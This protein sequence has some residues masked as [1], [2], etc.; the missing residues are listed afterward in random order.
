MAKVHYPGIYNNP[1]IEL[2]TCSKYLV[3]QKDGSTL[4]TGD[5]LEVRVPIRYRHYGM[6]E[7]TSNV[8]TLGLMDLIIDDKYQT[9]LNIMARVVL[10]PSESEETTID[11]TPYL[12]MYFYKGDTFMLTDNVLMDSD[13]NYAVYVEYITR[14]HRLYT[15]SYDD[16]PALFDRSKEL[17]GKAIDPLTLE[18]MVSHI[19][20]DPKN[21]SNQYRYTDFSK[22]PVIIH[23]RSINLSPTSTSTRMLGSYED[24][25]LTSS[26]N[27][28]VERR[29]TF[30]DI[31]RG[32]PL[33]E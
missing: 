21:M 8:E 10:C 26:L 7:V 28:T 23:L 4:F 12:V 25:G 14:G 17:T 9:T 2:D 6:L 24:D 19:A 20:R 11:D 1:L 33:D 13:I 3:R 16:I 30:E 32:I 31:L 22:P 15:V 27:T 29:Q 5:K 18:I